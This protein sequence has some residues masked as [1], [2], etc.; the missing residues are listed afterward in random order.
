M[1]DILPHRNTWPRSP[2]HTL[3]LSLQLGVALLQLSLQ[4]PQLAC[5][6]GPCSV[7][8]PELLSQAQPLLVSHRHLHHDRLYQLDC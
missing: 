8:Q 3:P 4:L 2:G 6:A 5:S 7:P 1:Q